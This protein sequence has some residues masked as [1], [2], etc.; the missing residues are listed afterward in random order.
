MKRG[1]TQE[2]ALARSHLPISDSWPP[3]STVQRH[4][5]TIGEVVKSHVGPGVL[6]DLGCGDGALV[7]SMVDQ[8]PRLTGVGCDLAPHPRW[9]RLQTSACMFIVG[10]LE[11][12]PFAPRTFD[13]V[14]AK[15][16]LHHCADVIATVERLKS[17]ARKRAIIVE[18]NRYNPISYVW[19]VRIGKH[20][21]LSYSKIRGI[22][23]VTQPI[24]IETHVWPRTLVAVG[25]A[26]EAVANHIV[27][28]RALRNYAVVVLECD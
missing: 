21:H 6:L 19:M 15:D 12:P 9:Q 14:V 17:L 22:A 18:A 3:P 27:A 16:L 25:R 23:P 20:E 24:M 11:A 28:F 10:D 7:R 13:Y 26:F 8:V 4:L 2:D 5:A 1:T